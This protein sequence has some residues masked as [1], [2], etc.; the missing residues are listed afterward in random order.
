MSSAIPFS[1]ARQLILRDLHTRY[2]GS[3]GGLFWAVLQPVLQL[4]IF[5]FVFVQV[6]KAKIPGADAPGYLAFLAVALWPWTAF[7]DAI[8]NATR[9]IEDNASLIGKVALP[10]ATLVFARVCASFAVHLLGFVVIVLAL[11]F[12]DDHVRIVRG[13]LP[14]LALY[15]PLFTLALGLALAM[16]ALQVFVRDLVQLLG[17]L[18]PLLLYCAPV[19]YDRAIVPVAIQP[20][21]SLNP[22]TFYA[23]AFHALVLGHGSVAW[24]SLAAAVTLAAGMLLAGYWLFR[25]LDRHF[26][27]FL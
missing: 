13:L 5:A 24:T 12:H 6:F 3:F 16:A 20:W 18:L 7:S 14:A 23:E 1:F 10:R 27:D 26:E 17:Q 15:V 11:S 8:L 19:F 4:V 22:F 2:T 25:R 9:A 21:L